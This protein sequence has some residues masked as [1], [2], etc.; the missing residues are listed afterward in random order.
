MNNSQG[1]YL[2]MCLLPPFH[3][4]ILLQLH[5]S[6][7]LGGVNTD[8]IFKENMCFFACCG[9]TYRHFSEQETKEELWEDLQEAE[10]GEQL[11]N[12][13]GTIFYRVKGYVDLHLTF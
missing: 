8:N 9:C 2:S 1:I 5:P 4:S 7:H 11:Q 3:T 12:N 6:T 13:K 10:A